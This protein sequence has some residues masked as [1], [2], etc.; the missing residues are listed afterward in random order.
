M[1]SVLVVDDSE[2]MRT[3]ICQ[4][5]KDDNLASDVFEASDGIKAVTAYKEIRPDL[6]TMDIDMPKANGIQALR[7][8][9]K[10][11]SRAKIIVVT[12][13]HKTTIQ[14]ASKFGAIGFLTKPLDKSETVWAIRMA[15]GSDLTSSNMK[16]IS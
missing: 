16:N 15:I 8:I 13:N 9:K 11:N 14:E 6:V 4:L 5:I 12:G 7:A 1:N 10:I 2:F 3:S